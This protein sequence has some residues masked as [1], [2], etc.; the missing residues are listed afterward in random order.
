MIMVEAGTLAY[1]RIFHVFPDNVEFL[2]VD[3]E[4]SFSC[5]W[6]IFFHIVNVHKCVGM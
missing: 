3:F 6:L 2:C 4:K 5:F 1:S